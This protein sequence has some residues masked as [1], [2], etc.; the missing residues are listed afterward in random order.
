MLDHLN[1]KTQALASA[2]CT[3]QRCWHNIKDLSQTLLRGPSGDITYLK[4]LSIPHRHD[5]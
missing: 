2:R 3:T 1:Y 5:A 4:E